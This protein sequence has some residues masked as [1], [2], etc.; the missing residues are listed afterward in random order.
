MND[1]N[2]ASGMKTDG[3]PPVAAGLVAAML[4][5]AACAASACLFL[6]ELIAGK[7]LLPLCGGAP[8][9]WITCLAFFQLVLVAAYRHAAHQIRHDSPGR[10]VVVQA[11]VFG[12]GAVISAISMRPCLS[13]SLA[14]DWPVGIRALILLAASI[15][16]VFF[17]L[18]TLAPLFG[19]WRGR[20][21]GNDDERGRSSYALYAAGNIGSFA[22][23]ICYP[24]VIETVLGVNQ[25]LVVAA[26]LYATVA[27]M[28]IGCGVF[29]ARYPARGLPV[30]T[31]G[32][33]GAG[34]QGLW[35]WLRWAGVA[36]I[37]SS[38]LAGVTTYATV[39]VAPLPLLWVVPLGAYLLSFAVVFSSGGR[40]WARVEPVAV[41]AAAGVA[42]WL[43]VG[44]ITTPTWPVIIAHIG[45]F[46][47]ACVGLH[48]VLVDEK[49]P[50]EHQASLYLAIAIGGAIGGLFNAIAAPL[51]FDA[52]HEFPLAIAAA[53]GVPV[54]SR[55]RWKGVI[56]WGA[57]AVIGVVVIMLCGSRLGA[58][59]LSRTRWLALIGGGVAIVLTACGTWGR[60]LAIIVLAAGAFL[61]TEQVDGVIHR[62]RTFFGVLRVCDAANGPSRTLVHGGITHGVQLVSN[63][64]ERRRIPLSYYAEAGPLGSVFRGIKTVRPIRRVGVAGLG[65]GTV[66][67]Y[68]EPGQEFVF[69]EIDPE[70]VR[71]ARNPDWFT[72]LADCRGDLRV[73]VDDARF[74]LAREPDASLDLL[75]V[76][77][78]TGDSVPTHLLTR[79]ALALYGRTLAPDGVVALHVS[80]KYLDFVPIVER[81]AADGGWMALRGFDGD[82]P[83]EFARSPSEWM[84]LTRSLDVI[85]AIYTSPTSDR[86]QWQPCAEKPAGRPWTDD[87]TAVA[88]ALRR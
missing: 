84:A 4:V 83:A 17:S 41:I 14:H 44:N 88:E 18:A 86:W 11:V 78:F 76:D 85:K 63:D 8:S 29:T 74:A 19:H 31:A 47:I 9:V 61:L 2:A 27:I 3:T 26:L 52:H 81:L 66:A 6:V 40:R 7:M 79:E 32:S 34:D 64:P 21:P 24:L 38:W 65:I 60:S 58:D 68:A 80:N 37:S 56:G 67:A 71:I 22:A 15:G 50:I 1:R 13:G 57:L 73:V 43:V 12:V 69:F 72:F 10:Q 39:E 51:I 70:V 87:R 36:A 46:F 54:V 35:T 48:G 53:A 77:A 59:W 82:V 20:W 25:Q 16:P 45:A 42:A 49:P 28:T 75:V 62:N 23:L 5:A 33:R 30:V 55:R